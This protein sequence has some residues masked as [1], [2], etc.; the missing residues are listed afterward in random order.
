MPEPIT[1]EELEA[2]EPD[3]FYEPGCVCLSRNDYDRLI[4]T[5]RAALS[6]WKR[7]EDE[8]PPHGLVVIAL[9]DGTF[10]Y[11][12]FYHSEEKR[13][14]YATFSHSELD[15]VTHWCK[16]PERPKPL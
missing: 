14:F 7:V 10:Y 12:G 4:A 5:A 16:Y 11:P 1:L 9:K 8:L 13:W 2:I 6:P 15:G 3:D